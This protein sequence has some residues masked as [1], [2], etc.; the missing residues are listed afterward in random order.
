[1]VVV[2]GAVV[3][4]VVLG[5]VVPGGVVVEV[6]GG[7][8]VGSVVLLVG[9]DVGEVEVGFWATVVGVSLP[10]DDVL[11]SGADTLSGEAGRWLT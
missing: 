8:V 11:N 3:F 9:T 1:M 4:V 7:A 2:E 5:A 6:F 10:V